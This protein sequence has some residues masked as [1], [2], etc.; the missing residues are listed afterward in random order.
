MG[1]KPEGLTCVRS[2]AYAGRVSAPI[3]DADDGL[4]VAG[5]RVG[6]PRLA[7]PEGDDSSAV[8]EA[9]GGSPDRETIGAQADRETIQAGAPDPLRNAANSDFPGSSHPVLDAVPH[10]E[11]VQAVKQ[12]MHSVRGTTPGHRG[13]WALNKHGDPCGAARRADSDYCNAHTGHGVAEDP[14]KWG[15][16]GAAKSADHRRRRATLRLALGETRLSTPRGVLR[17]AVFADAAAVAEA[18]MSPILDDSAS[19]TQRHNAALALIREVE[20]TAQVTVSTPLPSD[21]EGVKGLPLS[22]LLSI[23]QEHGITP[24]QPL[25]QAIP[26]L[27]GQQGE[28]EA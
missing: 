21:P 16:V 11:D 19:S 3:A 10:A 8:S 14:A 15:V 23:A 6:A 27:T 28:N 22:A 2:S 24:S 1:P 18:A 9:V 17:A 26:A 7:S 5:E 13:C 12:P 25:P 20:P 4:A